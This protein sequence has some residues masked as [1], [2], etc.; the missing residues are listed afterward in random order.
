MGQWGCGRDGSVMPEQ[1]DWFVGIDWA[2]ESHEVCVLDAERRVIDRQTIEHSGAKVSGLA[3]HAPKLLFSEPV[4]LSQ[5]SFFR[6]NLIS[7][8]SEFMNIWSKKCF[9]ALSPDSFFLYGCV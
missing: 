7:W 6:G 3:A 4:T 5:F 1:F 8:P 9:A 2:A